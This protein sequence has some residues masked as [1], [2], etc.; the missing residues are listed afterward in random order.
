LRCE[1]GTREVAEALT[2]RGIAIVRM[3]A[4]GLRN[5]E[6]ADNLFIS[7]GTVKIHLHNI[8]EKLKVGSRSHAH[9]LFCF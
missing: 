7:E 3:V 8:F 4:K 5:K 2:C 1:A 6:I 9:R